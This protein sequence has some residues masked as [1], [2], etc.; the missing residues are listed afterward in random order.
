MEK[1][2]LSALISI[3]PFT[4]LSHPHE[5]DPFTTYI[6]EKLI[7]L[8][9]LEVATG[10]NDKTSQSA[11]KL[12]QEK[13]GLIVDG[14]VGEQTFT[15]LLL[16][17]ATYQT[18][19][20][21]SKQIEETNS[22]TIDTL[23]PVWDEEQPPYASEIGSLFNLNM[24]AVTD[25]VGIVS[26]EV[27]VNGALSSYTFISDSTLLVT[28]KYDMTCG[29]QLIYVIAYDEAG[30]SSQSPSFTIPQT[31]PCTST[32]NS[33]QSSS[34]SQISSQSFAVSIGG[35]TSIF[36][37]GGIY[38]DAQNIVVDSVGNTYITGG[39]RDTGNFGVTNITS[40]GDLDIYVAKLDPTGAFEWVQT[41]G[42]TSNLADRGLDID[43]DSSS[44]VYITGYF[45]ETV[46]F[47]NGDITAA[48][49]SDIFVLKLDSSG[50]FQWV[51]TAG[52]SGNDNGKGIAVDTDGN[53]LLTGIYSQTVDF[54]GGNVTS[55][56]SFDI[57]VLKLNSSGAYQWVY[58]AGNSSNN[59][60]GYSIDTDSNN[61]SYI[62]GFVEGSV[63]F[64]GTTN[65]YGSSQL[66]DIF[67]LKLDSAGAVQWVNR[68]GSC[69]TEKAFGITVDSS[70]NSYITGQYFGCDMNFGEVT[71][72]YT[73][74][75]V[76]M[77]VLK[78]NSDGV[79]QWAYSAGGET[80]DHA[81]DAA[82]DSSG[83]VYVT[84][85]FQGTANF[86]SGNITSAGSLDI[87][88]LKLDSSGAFQWVYTAGGDEA[89]QG[90]GIALD[91]SGNVYT[92]GSFRS[93]I[94][95]TSGVTLEGNSNM[96]RALVFKLNSSGQYSD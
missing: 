77:F 13:Y 91:I 33:S 66:E 64:G 62:T 95:F 53:V 4:Q 23:A 43:I 54:G 40:G 59:D 89:D 73:R 3:L 27:F 39:F 49:G 41:Y 42:S 22:P 28:P 8:G 71:M 20:T 37:G 61:N 25:N 80:A 78:L 88:V 84:G 63:D 79:S 86:G 70:G 18:P 45:Q 82:V 1:I 74:G 21:T 24:P 16:G 56:G 11:I 52:G 67:V 90:N 51:Y 5:E 15:K 83:N 26:Y 57:F 36:Y 60:E 93:N 50:A 6:Q 10:V 81:V 92:A 35:G 17:E 76:E 34:S 75:G 14:M 2:I 85:F 55:T 69:S 48:G 31:D 68:Y 30:N 94:Q 72:T 47:G 7:E 87:F 9:Y 32:V 58:T 12:F 29:N 44:N 96:F 46:N 65:L 19:E 38:S